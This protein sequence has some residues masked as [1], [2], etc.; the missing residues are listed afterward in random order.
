MIGSIMN[1][2]F[3]QYVME[4]IN[5]KLVNLF[6]F[7][8]MYM[9]EKGINGYN[10]GVSSDGKFNFSLEENMIPAGFALFILSM[11]IYFVDI[12]S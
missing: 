11:L 1:G 9:G 10:N 7:Y 6:S 3:L 4:F 12:T 5:S 2:N 8:N